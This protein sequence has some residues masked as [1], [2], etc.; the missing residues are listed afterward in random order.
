MRISDWS[1]DVCSSDLRRPGRKA[2]CG[3]CSRLA[4]MPLCGAP[5]RMLEHAAM[6]GHRFPAAPGRFLTQLP[7]SLPWLGVAG[8]ATRAAGE[9][10]KPSGNHRRYHGDGDEAFVRT[11]ESGEG[12]ER[13][14]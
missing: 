11:T 4:R 3:H 8:P 2:S 1:S 14:I 10:L 13:E 6:T 5:L 9:A 12:K 7:A